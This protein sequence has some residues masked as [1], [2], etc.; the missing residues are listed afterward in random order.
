MAKIFLLATFGSKESRHKE[1]RQNMYKERTYY[2]ISFI[3]FYFYFILDI[4]KFKQMHCERKHVNV[5]MRMR[6]CECE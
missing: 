3:A 1:S 5:N 4:R 2:R 6:K